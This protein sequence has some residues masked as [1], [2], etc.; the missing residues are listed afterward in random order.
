M[1]NLIVLT[2]LFTLL[3]TYTKTVPNDLWSILQHYI[4]LS[5]FFCLSL[6]FMSLFIGVWTP[7]GFNKAVNATVMV[8][9]RM[10]T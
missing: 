8:R 4:T 6:T 10:Q 5:F 2:F 9:F 7:Q 1:R 3:I